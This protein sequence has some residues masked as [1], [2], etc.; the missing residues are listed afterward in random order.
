MTYSFGCTEIKQN[1][2]AESMQE[3][4]NPQKELENFKETRRALEE[5]LASEVL[6]ESSDEV[7]SMEQLVHQLDRAI[8]QLESAETLPMPRN[9]LLSPRFDCRKRKSDVNSRIPIFNPGGN[10]R[11]KASFKLQNSSSGLP[12]AIHRM[13]KMHVRGMY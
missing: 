1:K 3:I 12:I 2:Y 8:Q 13:K 6:S 10:V 9:G 11:Q 5:F 4:L 7:T